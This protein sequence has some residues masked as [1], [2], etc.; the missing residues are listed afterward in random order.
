MADRPRESAEPPHGVQV[1]KVYTFVNGIQ[2]SVDL[3][4][5]SEAE[6]TGGVFFERADQDDPHGPLLRHRAF[7]CALPGVAGNPAEQ[8]VVSVFHWVLA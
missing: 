6:A 8:V 1:L 4:A 5:V 2:R 7:Q 3:Q